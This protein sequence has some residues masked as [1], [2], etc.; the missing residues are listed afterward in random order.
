MTFF[1]M[2]NTKI[3]LDINKMKSEMALNVANNN[4]VLDKTKV[5]PL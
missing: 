1:F 2:L 3:E 4:A 5:D